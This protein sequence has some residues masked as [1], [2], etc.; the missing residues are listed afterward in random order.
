[1]IEMMGW[2][3]CLGLMLLASLAVG[4]WL[5]GGFGV[6]YLDQLIMFQCL[7]AGIP[8][9]SQAIAFSLVDD[10]GQHP[11]QS[12]NMV[13]LLTVGSLAVAWLIAEFTL[14]SLPNGDRN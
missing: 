3:L 12:D 1:M 11:K 14:R 13:L 9:A 8:V 5:T 4:V 6:V 7:G 2:P 10:L